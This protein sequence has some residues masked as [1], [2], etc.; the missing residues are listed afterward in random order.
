MSYRIAFYC[1][2]QHISYNLDTIEEEGVGGGI[3]SRIRMAHALASNGN[4]VAVFVNCPEEGIIRGVKYKHFS[5]LSRDEVDILIAGTSGGNFNLRSLLDVEIEAKLRILML[6]GLLPPEGFDALFFDYVYALSNF[7][8]N[9]VVRDWKVDSRRL[10]VTYRGV[11]DRI[12]EHSDMKLRDRDPYALCY[13]G[14]PS[15]GLKPAIEVITGLRNKDS[16][17]TL[18]VFGGRELWGEA[19]KND[20]EIPGVIHHGV[21]GQQ[22]LA[23]R[24]S[25]CTFSLCLQTREEPFGMVVIESMKAGCIVIASSVGAYPEIIRHGHDGFL[26]KRPH[27]NAGIIQAGI[28]LVMKLFDNHELKRTI[29]KNAI[30]APFSWKTIA[31]VW[32]Q[33][34]DWKIAGKLVKQGGKTAVACSECSAS[35]L[36][37]LDGNHCPRCGSYQRNWDL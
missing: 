17:F 12:F 2:D 33:H 28:D 25:Q 14:H 30:N 5:K 23:G 8:R 34:W 31:E 16:R 27:E 20:L 19:G 32:E 7:V 15:K 1:P 9:V 21:V 10:F 11:E 3:T 35:M 6:H 37:F 22:E 13:V 36:V 4:D 24:M 26:V 29:R 18:H